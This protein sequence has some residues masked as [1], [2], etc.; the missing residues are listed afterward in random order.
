MKFYFNSKFLVIAV[1]LAGIIDLLHGWAHSMMW[2][3]WQV[4][5]LVFVS[6]VVAVYSALLLVKK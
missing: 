5:K 2:Q 3:V 1:I 4:G 6:V